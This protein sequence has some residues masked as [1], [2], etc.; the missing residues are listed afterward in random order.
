MRECFQYH[1]FSAFRVFQRV[2]HLLRG[3]K[4][5]QGSKKQFPKTLHRLSTLFIGIF[6]FKIKLR[7]KGIYEL[8]DTLNGKSEHCQSI[9]FLC[10]QPPSKNEKGSS[11]GAL[12]DSWQGGGYNGSDEC[13]RP[14]QP[15]VVVQDVFKRVIFEQSLDEGSLNLR[16]KWASV[17]LRDKKSQ[18]G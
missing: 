14:L 12:L 10:F 8:P 15:S 2:V 18:S 9:S 16:N 11:R 17:Y 7:S 3:Q 5:F 6:L 4:N 1:Q 13:S